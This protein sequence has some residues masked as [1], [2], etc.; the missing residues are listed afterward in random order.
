MLYQSAAGIE[1]GTCDLS[2]YYTFRKSC[3]QMIFISANKL[4]SYCS[5]I[6]IK[7]SNVKRK[8]AKL[9]DLL[10]AIFFISDL[11]KDKKINKVFNAVDNCSALINTSLWVTFTDTL[12]RNFQQWTIAC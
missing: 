1:A 9:Y 3:M 12:Q 4:K 10:F 8:D 6:W 7:L 2:D 5:H 11:N